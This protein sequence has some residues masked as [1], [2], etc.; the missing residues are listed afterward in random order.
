MA[1]TN[2]E[3]D[4]LVPQEAFLFSDTIAHNIAF[5]LDTFNIQKV[6]QA[7]VA[8][9]VHGNIIDFPKGYETKVGERGITLS[10]G[11]KQRVSIARALAKDPKLWS[12]TIV[13]VQWI[14]KPKSLSLA[15]LKKQPPSI[16][17]MIIAHRVSSVKHCEQIICLTM[18]PSLRKAPMPNLR[19]LV[20]I[21][22]N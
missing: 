9:G 13:S 6:E 11:Q 8:A 1:F 12:S 16:S 5:G 7:A 10:G 18:G 21:I 3:E 4:L 14:Q 19:M 20:D 2:F 22:A 17:S 15:T